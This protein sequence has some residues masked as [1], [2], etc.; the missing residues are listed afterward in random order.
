MSSSRLPSVLNPCFF[1]AFFRWLLLIL[2]YFLR[3]FFDRPFPSLPFFLPFL[4]LLFLSLPFFSF[5]SPFLSLSFLPPVAL[6]SSTAAARRSINSA[7]L[8]SSLSPRAC[9]SLRRS[10]AFISAYS[11]LTASMCCNAAS[12]AAFSAAI[13]AASAS[14]ISGISSPS[15]MASTRRSMS[16]S[17]VPLVSRY[18]AL[19]AFFRWLLLM[20]RCS[21]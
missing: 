8:P 20:S 5:P 13:C 9:S 6:S 1:N 3:S 19:S 11:G 7:F 21:S 16:S 2:A 17:L 15:A 14:S 18:I 10:G 12:F 4:S